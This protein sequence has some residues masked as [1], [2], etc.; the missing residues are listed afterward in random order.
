MKY[1]PHID[2]MPDFKDPISSPEQYQ[3]VTDKR[4]A[5]EKLINIAT[6]V[7]D[8]QTA[9]NNLSIATRPSQTFPEKAA[10]YLKSITK[11]LGDDSVEDIVKKLDTIEAI[12]Q[13]ALVQILHLTEIDVNSLRDNQIKNIDVKR[14]STSIDD[15]KR[16]THTSLALRY[17][18]H[19]RGVVIA[20]CKL[21]ISQGEIREQVV[22]LKQKEQQCVEQIKLEINTIIHDTSLIITQKGISD[23]VKNDL[24][25][26]HQAML[27]NLEHLK[28]GGSIT[29]IPNVFEIITLQLE[30]PTDEPGT[31]N[32]DAPSDKGES[33]DNNTEPPTEASSSEQQD[34]GPDDKPGKISFW[35]HLKI[36]LTSSWGTRWS[37]IKKQ[38]QNRDI[39][40]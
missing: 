32:A 36:W 7:H 35:R 38:H 15:F 11:H 23:E 27:V 1:D 9:L 21:H 2:I 37:S 26:V 22:L 24:A 29:E 28:N 3:L 39:E 12:I 20:P 17:V 14:F 4:V 33:S 5:L 19:Q 34:T 30:P 10:K 18:L 8:Q 6:G 25:N 13:K 31:A 16:R 40:K